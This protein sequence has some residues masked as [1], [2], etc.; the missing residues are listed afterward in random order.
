MT[1]FLTPACCARPTIANMDYVRGWRDE[2]ERM[3]NRCCTRC[4]THWAGPEAGE[5]KSYSSKEWDKHISNAFADCETA[6]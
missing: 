3:V 5:V 6:Q 2:S 1:A 4:W